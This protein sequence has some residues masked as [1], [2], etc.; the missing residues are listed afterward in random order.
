[1]GCALLLACPVFD[2]ATETHA[3]TC[4]VAWVQERGLVTLSVS[5]AAEQGLIVHVFSASCNFFKLTEEKVDLEHDG[6][7]AVNDSWWVKEDAVKVSVLFYSAHGLAHN[8]CSPL[9]SWEG[10][11]CWR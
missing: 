10:D 1:M 4:T 3:V 11:I 5:A 6:S 8:V 9:R 2:P 7:A